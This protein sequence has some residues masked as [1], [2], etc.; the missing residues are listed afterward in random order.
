VRYEYQNLIL[1]IALFILSEISILVY[2]N[3]FSTIAMVCVLIVMGIRLKFFGRDWK[4]L[5][6]FQ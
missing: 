5:L 3:I 4:S 1:I 6:N 2:E